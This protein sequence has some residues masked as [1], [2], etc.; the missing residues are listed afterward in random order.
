MDI[1]PF[2]VRVDFPR[3][4]FAGPT[5]F[6][7]FGNAG[8]TVVSFSKTKRHVHPFVDFFLPPSL[9]WAKKTPFWSEPQT[10]RTSMSLLKFM[11]GK[12]KLPRFPA[13]PSYG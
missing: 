3:F 2:R 4:S 8:N 13:A 7:C 10:K 1:F 11:G 12:G 9:K 6:S 5:K